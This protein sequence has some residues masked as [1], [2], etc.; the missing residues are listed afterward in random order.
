MCCLWFLL[1]LVKCQVSPTDRIFES[2]VHTFEQNSHKKV[3]SPVILTE[4][5]DMGGNYAG[6]CI[7]YSNNIRIIKISKKSWIFSQDAGKEQLLLHELGH[8]ELNYPHN[9]EMIGYR[10]KS[11]MHR[12]AFGDEFYY[13]QYHN[14]YFHEFF[15]RPQVDDELFPENYK[16]DLFDN[17]QQIY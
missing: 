17:F 4:D 8:C 16:N 11:I 7:I 5:K 10:P 9:N 12:Q 14:E 6:L 2:I 1:C 3:N 13:T 15:D